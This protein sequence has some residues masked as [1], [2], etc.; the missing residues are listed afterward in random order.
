MDD[1]QQFLDE[2]LTLANTSIYKIKCLN[3]IRHQYRN[4]VSGPFAIFSVGRI[5][6]IRGDSLVFMSGDPIELMSDF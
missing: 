1:F 3:E 2:T 5:T 4:H 6:E